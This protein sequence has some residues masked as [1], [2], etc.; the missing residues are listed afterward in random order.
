MVPMGFR[1]LLVL[2]LMLQSIIAVADVHWLHQ[3]GP[4]HQAS[5]TE[6]QSS[7]AAASSSDFDGVVKKIELLKDKPSFDHK[8]S[9]CCHCHGSMPFLAGHVLDIGSFSANQDGP[10]LS[11]TFISWLSTPA[12]RPP[13]V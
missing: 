7:T 8:C 2:M 6:Q 11:L 3:Q 10:A 9:H 1:L 13:I 4:G 12:L 5:G